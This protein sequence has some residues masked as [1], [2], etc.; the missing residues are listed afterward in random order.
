MEGSAMEREWFCE[1]DVFGEDD[2]WQLCGNKENFDDQVIH[3][4]I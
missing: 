2:C 3:H 4:L 1:R